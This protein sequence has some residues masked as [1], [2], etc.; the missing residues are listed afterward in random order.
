MNINQ[1]IDGMKDELIKTV[2]TC[3]Q[4]KSV[5]DLDS[6]SSDAPF[7]QGIK[8]CLEWTLDLGE[9]MGFKVKNVDGYAGHIELGTGE[10]VGI[11]GHLDVVPEGDGWTVPP[12]EGKIMDGKIYGRGAVDDKG[13]TLAALFAMKAIKDLEIP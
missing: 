9:K 10:L 5:K 13:P 1:Y 4:F 2:Q 8:E 7:G 6:A 12:Y 11:L 3:I